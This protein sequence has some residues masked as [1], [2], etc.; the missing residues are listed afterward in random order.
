MGLKHWLLGSAGCLIACISHAQNTELTDLSA[1]ITAPAFIARG[2]PISVSLKVTNAGPNDAAVVSARLELGAGLTIARIKLSGG[3]S[4]PA[5]GALGTCLDTGNVLS[6]SLPQLPSGGSFTFDVVTS[7]TTAGGTF[8]HLGFVQGSGT[9]L[10][11]SNNSTGTVTTVQETSQSVSM[12][13]D[14]GGGG[15]VSLW[16]LAALLLLSAMRALRVGVEQAQPNVSSRE[17]LFTTTLG[18]E[19]TSG[20]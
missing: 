4:T 1:T 9:D 13:K 5:P 12:T 6:C 2:E 14:S 16:M 11:L 3:T 17:P 20:R 8:S 18:G 10:I 19:V 7:A 15:S